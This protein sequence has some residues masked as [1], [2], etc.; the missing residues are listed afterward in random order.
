MAGPSLESLRPRQVPRH[1]LLWR[2]HTAL[3]SPIASLFAG[4]GFGAG[5]LSLQS[6]TLS[7]IGILR[8]A[9]GNWAHAA[10]GALIVY[11]GLLLDRADT[12]LAQRTQRP[13]AWGVFVG[14]VVD[15]LVEAGL[16]VALGLL[17]LRGL[18]GVPAPL[19]H[20]FA[21]LSTP[22]FLLL[23][24]VGIALLLLVR[25]VQAYA[26][27][28]ALRSHLIVTRR[29]PGPSLVRRPEAAERLGLFFDR[30]L[31]V[32]AWVVGVLLAQV[33]LTLLVVLVAHAIALV[34]LVILFWRRRKDPEPQAARV[35]AGE[36]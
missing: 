6:L 21:P 33:Q 26:D 5:P 8:L 4:F 29:L 19:A 12:L 11:L 30:D 24:G 16:L 35:L 2:F 10:Q 27:L 23:V 14:L 31:F 36:P 34:E 15:R 18:A 9:T 3:A 17:A 7:A 20:P 25:L 28:L 22:I 1:G 32:V 13:A